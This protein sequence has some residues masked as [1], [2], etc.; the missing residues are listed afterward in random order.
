MINLNTIS[1]RAPTGTKKNLAKREL[2]ALHRKIFHWQN[3]LFAEGKHPILIILQGMDTSGKDGT[4]RH[5]FSCVNPMGCNVKS[6]KA[7]TERE[8]KHDFLWRIY[9]HLPERGMIQIFNRSHYE[10]ILVPTVHKTLSRERIEERFHQINCLEKGL[11]KE[12]TIIWKFFLHISKGEQQKRIEARKQNPQKKWKYAISDE[13][14]AKNWEDYQRIYEKILFRCSPEIPW[15]IVPADQKWYRN[16]YV[17]KY[18]V[19]QLEQLNL[20]YP[21]K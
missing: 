12:G 16:Y 5:V 7:P 14:E 2:G 18:I 11:R 6:F 4:I 1:T 8:Q 17:A 20:Q 19:E 13:K 3:V 10:D 9:Q 21:T 15:Q